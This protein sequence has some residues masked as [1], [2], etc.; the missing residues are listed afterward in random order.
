MSFPYSI[1][2]DPL[3]KMSY[4]ALQVHESHIRAVAHRDNA[5]SRKYH[6]GEMV[7]SLRELAT[8]LGFDL[9]ARDPHLAMLGRAEK[10]ARS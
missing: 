10:E 4:A 3:F 9:V 5:D 8:A 6:I 7:A 1:M 2:E